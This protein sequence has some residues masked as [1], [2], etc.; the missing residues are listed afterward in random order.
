MRQR[1]SGKKCTM[2]QNQSGAGSVKKKKKG[3]MCL[4]SDLYL[5]YSLQ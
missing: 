3:S 1:H 5:F 2:N 4:N